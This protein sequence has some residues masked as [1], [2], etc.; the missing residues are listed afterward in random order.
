MG[1]VAGIAVGVHWSVLVI[2]GLLAWG[3]AGSLLPTAVPGQPPG[4]Y[5]AAG[6]LVATTFFGC[7]LAHELAHA[8]VARWFGVGVRRIT[9]WLLGG[10]SELDE[11]AP[12]PS[13]ELAIAGAGPLMS[14]LLGAAGALGLV[15]ARAAG[16]GDL[17]VASLAW[18]AGVNVVLAVFNL[19]PGAPLDGGRVLRAVLW[20]I[21]GDRYAAQVSA[22]RAGSVVGLLLAVG[23]IVQILV[24]GDLSGL[25]L[26]LLG[27][28]LVWAAT[29]E[30]AS[31]RVRAVLDRLTVAQI[32]TPRPVCAPAGQIIDDFVAT[33][34]SAA[35]HRV[36]PVV[37]GGHR[38][39]GI[40]HLARLTRVAPPDRAVLR[41]AAVAAPAAASVTVRPWD[42]ASAVTRALGPGSPLL[43]VVD[44]GRVVVGVVT[45]DDVDRAVEL[46]P[47]SRP[48]T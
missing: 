11:E 24:A 15:W 27:W 6:L 3:L 43:V 35:R 13:A 16:L 41:V 48:A 45:V 36:F 32:M 17:V 12:T 7:V 10:V 29:A 47:L 42:P 26:V 8:I 33:V 20:R 37:D 19:L 46:A 25:W 9:L 4:A 31:A 30:G 2:V 34:A 38:L 39:V 44:D 23:G 22:D 21:R 28:Y 40:L 1:R 5:L 14:L 18:L